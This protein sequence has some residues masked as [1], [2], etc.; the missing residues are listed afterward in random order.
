M[1]R[2]MYF[3]I[4]NVSLART[5]HNELLLSRVAES[6]MHVIAREDVDLND[7]PEA[8]ILQKSDLIH[9]IQTGLPIGGLTGVVLGAVAVS[10]GMVTSGYEGV[11]IMLTVFAGLFLGVFASTMIAVN[12]PNTRHRRFEDELSKGQILFIV[13]VPV[14]KVKE[15]SDMVSKHHPEA[16]MRGVEPNI[17]AFP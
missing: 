1:I 13:D 14:E 17:P 5:I 4:P 2:R 9:S 11:T 16:D 8:N 12:V 10:S 15:I 7:L 6:K 3:I